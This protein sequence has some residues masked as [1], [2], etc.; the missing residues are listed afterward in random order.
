[1]RRREFIAGLGSTVMWPAL[2]HAQQGGAPAIV[3]LLGSGT[4]DAEAARAFRE[5]LAEAGFVEGR[6]LVIEYRWAS[7]EY[8]RLPALA[9]ELV[10]RSV[11]VI[12][13]VGSPAA[14]AAQRATATIPIVFTVANDP[15][16]LGLVKS[17]NRPESNLT[18][19]SM[20]NVEVGPKRLELLREVARRTDLVGVLVNPTH[21]NATAN[22]RDLQEPARR[23][24]VR[25]SV[26]QAKGDD[27]FERAFADVT[28]SG[29][30]GLVIGPDPLFNNQLERLA[31]MTLRHNLPAIYHYR[32][33]ALAGGLMSYGSN[34]AVARRQIGVYAGRLLK[35]ARP[36]ELPVQQ[37]TKL[38]LFVNLKT[39]KTLGVTIPPSLLASADEVIE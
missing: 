7:G 20:L 11:A 16:G 15:I 26:V 10:A 5:G 2:A 24:G 34:S 27:E 9:A 35:G 18:G 30:A 22:L 14:T 8:R 29:A 3:G 28:R 31:G 37:S 32:E 13:A 17:L 12:G 4:P 21:P 19:V 25:L 6:N 36:S 38:E 33:F 39:A 1:M 23:L